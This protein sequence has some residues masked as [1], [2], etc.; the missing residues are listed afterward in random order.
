MQRA[1]WLSSTLTSLKWEGQP[2]EGQVLFS[3][4]PS[5]TTPT[6]FKN[7]TKHI[8]G[9]EQG[10]TGSNQILSPFILSKA[11]RWPKRPFGEGRT[12][13]CCGLYIQ[14]L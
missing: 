1:C 5:S 8:D 6:C 7:K 11:Y 3:Q 2:L 12:S 10:C 9:V 13:F 4:L 14:K